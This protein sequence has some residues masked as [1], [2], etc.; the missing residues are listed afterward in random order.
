MRF[1]KIYEENKYSYSKAMLG[2]IEEIFGR[3]IS[4]ETIRPLLKELKPRYDSV[5]GKE[6]LVCDLNDQ[7]REQE[8]PLP[9]ECQNNSLEN[10]EL[11]IEDASTVSES[12]EV[13][14]NN[15][16]VIPPNSENNNSSFCH[17]VGIV[18]FHEI[19]KQS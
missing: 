9:P 16:K 6:E 7:N 11:V 2:E 18:L 12:E 19:F 13:N 14:R 8:N 4:S 17:H 15:R 5:T 1:P 10:K 3:K